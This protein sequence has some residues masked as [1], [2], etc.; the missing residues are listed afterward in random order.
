MNGKTSSPSLYLSQ[1]YQDAW[2]DYNRSLHSSTFP[3]WDYIILTAS[4]E[5]QAEAFHLQIES[6][7]EYL[8][9]RTK[10]G[11]IPDEGGVRVGSG[12]ATLSVLKWLDSQGGWKGK[13][14][15]VIHSGGDSKRV[16]QYSALGKLFSPVPHMLPGGAAHSSMNS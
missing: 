10:I 7:R 1:S 4:N 14:V 6:R 12:G 3:V 16:P 15:L 8:P 11:I 9:A 13:R 5:H 2:D